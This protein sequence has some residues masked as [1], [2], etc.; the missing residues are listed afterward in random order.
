[1]PNIIVCCVPYYVQLITLMF[2][3]MSDQSP[4][5]LWLIIAFS[6]PP[7]A[8]NG[9]RLIELLFASVTRARVTN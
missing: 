6:L 9:L 1:M 8:E 4:K 7:F 3:I 2:S 5:D